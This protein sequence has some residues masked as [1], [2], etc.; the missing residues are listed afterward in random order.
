MRTI[1]CR[2]QLAAWRAVWAKKYQNAWNLAIMT[3]RN[4]E[5][6]RSLATSKQVPMTM[7]DTHVNTM[8]DATTK[9]WSCVEAYVRINCRLNHFTV[10]LHTI[11]INISL[12]HAANHDFGLFSITVSR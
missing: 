6:R 9:S 4:A 5:E 8:K 2:D 11:Q 7:L 10:F 1:A 3:L 12:R